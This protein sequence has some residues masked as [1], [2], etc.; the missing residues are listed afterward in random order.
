ADHVGGERV[1]GELDP[2]ELER[3]APPQRPR[4]GRLADSGHVLDEHVP[5]GEQRGQEQVHRP[6]LA[7]VG[8]RDVFA[9][10]REG[11]G[12]RVHR[13]SLS[14]FGRGAARTPA[15]AARK[16]PSPPNGRTRAPP[17]PATIAVSWTPGAMTG[18]GDST[19]LPAS[20]LGPRSSRTE[21]HVPTSLHPAS[22]GTARIPAALSMTA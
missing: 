5:A 7:A 18:T 12:G 22:R 21:R 6:R 4:Q 13:E 3:Q 8:Q 2:A 16:A 14:P 1:A 19:R 15:T 11:R 17:S 10:L 20:S 9:Q